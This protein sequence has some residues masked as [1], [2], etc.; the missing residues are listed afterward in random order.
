VLGVVAGDEVVATE[1]VVAGVGGQDVPSGDEQAAG[2]VEHSLSSSTGTLPSAAWQAIPMRSAA[3]VT[4]TGA[5]LFDGDL[6]VVAD[7]PD[8]AIKSLANL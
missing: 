1:T 5:D 6:D 2:D 7:R 4:F 3:A 8:G